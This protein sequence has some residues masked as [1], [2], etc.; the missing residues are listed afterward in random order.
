M[1]Q[2]ADEHTDGSWTTRTALTV[3]VGADAVDSVQRSFCLDRCEDSGFVPALVIGNLHI[4]KLPERYVMLR[5]LLR[6]VFC[7]KHGQS[8]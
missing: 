1:S 2:R 3:D 5:P 6:V 8:K 7:D 4:C